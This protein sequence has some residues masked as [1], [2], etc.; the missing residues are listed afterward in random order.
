MLTAITLIFKGEHYLQICKSKIT[1]SR[2]VSIKVVAEKLTKLIS[3][4][5]IEILSSN[6]LID[7]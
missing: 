6:S 3:I 1:C 7:R 4:N 2:K 5:V